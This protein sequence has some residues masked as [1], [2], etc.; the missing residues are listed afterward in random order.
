MVG[1]GMFRLGSV[2]AKIILL[3]LL[4]VFGVATV[5]AVNTCLS[6]SI[7]RNIEIGR[8]SHN[9]AT[10][11]LEAG[12]IQEK[13]INTRSEDL[14]STY[15]EIRKNLEAA[16]SRLQTLSRGS[17]MSQAVEQI[18]AMDHNCVKVFDA[19]TQNLLS[20]HTC[21]EDI[22]I[23]ID[24][25][26][27]LLR[28]VVRDSEDEDVLLAIQGESL[29]ANKVSVRSAFKEYLAIWDERLINIQNLLLFANADSYIEA[30]KKFSSELGQKEKNLTSLLE[31]L[32]FADFRDSWNKA[33][34]YL[35]QIDQ[36]EVTLFSD[37]KSNQDL[38]TK[39]DM[40]GRNVSKSALEINETVTQQ[41]ER[42]SRRGDLLTL[43][44]A[45]VGTVSLAIVGFI[46]VRAITKT[47][48]HSIDSL[49]EIAGQVE[50]GSMQLAGSS[51]KLAE[52]TSQQ[53]ASIEETSS[54][55]EEM[56]SMTQQNA[57]NASQV[58]Q[59]MTEVTRVVEKANESMGFLTSSIQEISKAS[60]DTQKIIQTIDAIAFQT[61]LLALNA[62]VEAARAG[63]SG[64]GFAVV[65]DEVRNL[66]MR[67]SEAAR[68]T[69]N[70]IEGTVMKV[71]E[72][73]NLVQGTNQEFQKVAATVMKSGELVGEIAV[74]SR[75]QAQGI[76]QIS[77]AVSDMDKVTQEN[78][79]N[80]EESASAS[81]EMNLQAEQMR[82]FIQGLVA[83]VG[84]KDNGK[85]QSIS[86]GNP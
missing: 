41:I 43:L 51:Q 63:E 52:G 61:N 62:A 56:S 81:K 34:V 24:E 16:I 28:K 60:A 76:E 70:L 39:L 47:L 74:A 54:S 21:R 22:K 77:S 55:L 73:S 10:S 19:I 11:I 44:I 17:S 80:A 79:A 71:K 33:R 40:A 5:F 69:A 53:A 7:K 32:D 65:A 58:H 78:T 9:V 50:L 12:T 75:E 66:A 23:K 35:P 18:V 48:N 85:G 86:S 4:G 8:A 45:I 3:A 37:W 31:T 25:M 15:R 2:R 38:M 14:L 36:L 64:A 29:D 57:N 67:A 83:L 82:E 68:N 6:F 13:F 1:F 30:V 72:G 42:N 20:M 49:S 46:I 59:L 27:G 84:G 26:R